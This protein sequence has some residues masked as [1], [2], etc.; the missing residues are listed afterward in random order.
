[1]P[2][3]VAT[4]YDRID[5]DKL[6]IA[7]KFFEDPVAPEDPPELHDHKPIAKLYVRRAASE[8]KARLLAMRE[9]NDV[10]SPD[11][12]CEIVKAELTPFFLRF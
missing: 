6:V 10:L 12:V 8:I 3:Y 11:E 1:M 7:R 9:P 4:I 2:I 5:S